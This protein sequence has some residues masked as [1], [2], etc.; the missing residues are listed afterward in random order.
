[1]G[2]M[3]GGKGKGRSAFHDT[4]K[5]IMKTDPEKRVY[6]GGLPEGTKWKGLLKHFEDSGHKPSLIEAF[7]NKTGVAVFDSAEAAA[8]AI[9]A[10][11]G[12]S[13]NGQR[14]SCEAWKAKEK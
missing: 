2:M 10:L 9:S 8:G 6:I 5:Q 13:F 12:S 11:D 14:I 4:M 7:Y 3:K 1:M